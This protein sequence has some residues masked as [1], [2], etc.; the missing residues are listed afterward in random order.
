M[1]YYVV[2]DSRLLSFDNLDRL[3]TSSLPVWSASFSRLLQVDLDVVSRSSWSLSVHQKRP[4]DAPSEHLEAR[5][6]SISPWASGALAL[7]PSAPTR[8][9]KAL[10][11]NLI[12]PQR[13]RTGLMLVAVCESI[14]PP[15]Q[16][17]GAM[18][19][20]FTR[21]VIRGHAKS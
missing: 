15:S 17:S 13:L 1:A 21:S 20:A 6:V 3:T 19:V 7:R 8:S 4:N 2:C 5:F 11:A 14:D 12:E 9:W 16:G 10:P 18:V